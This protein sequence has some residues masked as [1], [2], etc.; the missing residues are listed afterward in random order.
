MKI[1]QALEK[2]IKVLKEAGVETPSLDAQIILAHILKIP[3]W[4]LIVQS[5]EELTDRELN[6]F[7]SLIKKRAERFPVAY[8]I[9]EKEFFGIKFIVNEGVLIPRPETEILVET[10]LEKIKDRKEPVGIEVGVGSGAIAV[11]LLKNKP[12]LKIIATDISNIAIE[13]S[14]KNAILHKVDNRLKILK[15]DKLNSINGKFDFIVSNP[16]YI[17]YY[18]YET[19]QPEVK[20][21]PKLALLAKDNGLEFYKDI[22]KKGYNLLKR[23]GFFAFE[24][25]YNQ[26]EEV[27]KL[28]Q[29]KGLKTEKIKDLQ[30]IHRVV[31]GEKYEK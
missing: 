17:P 30:G 3:R 25:G 18:E 1:K 22:I 31:I 8:I 12:D 7:F 5:D 2:A 28:L 11:S 21:E 10:V 26:A 16:P 14:K 6:T 23:N 20:K 24:V 13:T 4:K 27:E 19:L 29:K 9:G 15:A